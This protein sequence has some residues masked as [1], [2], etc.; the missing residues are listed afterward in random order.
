MSTSTSIMAHVH[1]YLGGLKLP[2]DLGELSL[3]WTKLSG[4]PEAAEKLARHFACPCEFLANDDRFGMEIQHHDG[5]FGDITGPAGIAFAQALANQAHGFNNMQALIAPNLPP[6][7]RTMMITKVRTDNLNRVVQ[8][9]G[10]AQ[11]G[12]ARAVTDAYENKWFPSGYNRSHVLVVGVFIHPHAGLGG[13][14]GDARQFLKGDALEQSM[15]AIFGLN[16]LATVGLLADALTGGLTD[17]ERV[18]RAKATK[19]PFRGFKK[20][21]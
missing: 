19:H 16:Y 11:E 5:L 2:D 4:V 14:E 9:W 21:A 20:K 6:P 7:I 1:E 3:D 12:I 18:Q 8:L 15:H 17:T 13:L 10:A